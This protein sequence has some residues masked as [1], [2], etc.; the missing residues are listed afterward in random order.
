MVT[1]LMPTGVHNHV[2]KLY[3]TTRYNYLDKYSL[4]SISSDYFHQLASAMGVLIKGS[5]RSTFQHTSGPSNGIGNVFPLMHY[6]SY[7]ETYSYI[8]STVTIHCSEQGISSNNAMHQFNIKQSKCLAFHFSCHVTVIVL[9][10][11]DVFMYFIVVIDSKC[12]NTY[13]IYT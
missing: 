13:Y 6:P 2:S 9:S 12:T 7:F 11:Y 8:I 5:I 3:V 10:M 4:I 1:F